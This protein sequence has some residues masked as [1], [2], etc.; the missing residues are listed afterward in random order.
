MCGQTDGQKETNTCFTEYTWRAGNT[1]SL[2]YRVA[3]GSRSHLFRR[4]ADGWSSCL[5]FWSFACPDRTAR[6]SRKTSRRIS[7]PVGDHRG[8]SYWLAG[9]SLARQHVDRQSPTNDVTE[10]HIWLLTNRD[11]TTIAVNTWSRPRFRILHCSLRQSGSSINQKKIF[12]WAQRS[13]D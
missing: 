7:S 8:R 3:A 4:T 1:V 5:A 2:H 11:Q 12:A 10:W 13:V 9:R 6:M